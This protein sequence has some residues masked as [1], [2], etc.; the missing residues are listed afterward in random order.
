M[1]TLLVVPLLLHLWGRE[2]YGAWLALMA[3]LNLLSA[4]DLGHQGYL[5]NEFNISAA[6]G[7]SRLKSTLSSGLKTAVILGIGQFLIAC[8]FV[9]ANRTDV[10]LGV[11]QTHSS[12]QQLDRA[13]L[14][15]VGVWCVF[16]STSGLL[17]RLYPARGLYARAQWFSVAQKIVL[18]YGVVV[19]VAVAGGEIWEF[20]ITYS[21][22]GTLIAGIWF[23]EFRTQLRDLYPWWKG[24]SWRRAWKNFRASLLLTAN[25]F[26]AQ[27]TT[28]GLNLLIAGLFDVR[29]VP[30]FATLRTVTNTFVQAVNI[31]LNPL[32]PDLIRF[33]VQG[34]RMKVVHT[35]Q[36]AFIAGGCLILAILAVTPLVPLAFNYWTQGLIPLDF[37]LYCLLACA[38]CIKIAYSPLLA[39]LS[40]LNNIRVQTEVNTVQA[41]C[42]LGLPLLLSGT[43][44]LWVFGLGLMLGEICGAAICALRAR[45]HFQESCAYEYLSLLSRSAV[46][47]LLV[48]LGAYSLMLCHSESRT[49]VYITI[50]AV[51]CLVLVYGAQWYRLPEPLRR[52]IL[53]L[54]RWPGRSA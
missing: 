49:I 4:L 53:S 42:A 33:H 12:L 41:A 20:A 39:Y 47:P 52:R 43:E 16:G 8:A 30:A 7:A 6:K 40:A 23:V 35:I 19:A 1:L 45:L 25:G 17:V 10:L 48:A 27:L 26:L 22:V 24:G 37:K 9:A 32:L 3:A 44:A 5:G 14:V 38:V 51:V 34:E 36:A 15:L 46:L 29:M 13:L 2:S 50:S 54:A 11:S 31:I 18:Q 28:S 21:V